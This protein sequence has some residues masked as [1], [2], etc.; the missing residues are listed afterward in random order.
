[1]TAGL[2]DTEVSRHKCLIYDG[3]PA[4]QLPVVVPLLVDGLADNWRCLYL[5]DPGT[6]PIMERALSEH[7]VDTRREQDRGALILSADRSHLVGGR[8]YPEAMVAA[9]GKLIDESVAQGF[10]GLCATGDMRWELGDDANFAHLREYEARLEQLFRDKPL[11]GICQYR[12]DVVPAHAV[13][14]ALATHRST[15]LGTALNRDN[16][17]YIPPEL[18]LEGGGAEQQT[19]WM[20][21]QIVRIIKAEE[22]RDRALQ[23]LAA[24]N[25]NLERRVAERTAELEA[26]NRHL[27]AFAYSVSHDLRAPLRAIGG[28]SNILREDFAQTLGAE[29]AKHIDR[30]VT[31]VQRMSELIEGMLQLSKIMKTE[32]HAVRVD[33]TALAEEVALELRETDP[34]RSAEFVIHRSLSAVADRVLLRALLVNL[35]S[36]AWKFTGGRSKARIE[37]G[38]ETDAGGQRVFYVRDNG[39]GF[40]VRKAE[41]LFAPFQRFHRQ[42]EFPGT[43]VGLATV[44]RIVARH[45]GRIWVESEPNVGTT[46]F[47]TLG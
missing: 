4:E 7:G 1:M 19:E 34:Q 24:T 16:L 42:E 36:N 27:E 44:Q 18:L 20:Y 22:Q 45:G 32:L 30:V 28:F 17:F 37:V 25:Q 10:A 2:M 47:F 6:L 23:E 12:R 21:Q 8:F 33:V 38:A 26:A 39:A 31:Q 14:D 9:I 40:D 29:G 43:G 41:R 35:I 15:Y 3:E 13:R 5:A 46:F 11:R